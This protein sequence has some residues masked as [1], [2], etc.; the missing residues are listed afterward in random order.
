MIS[1]YLPIA[2]LVLLG[3]GIAMGTIGL[4]GD[5]DDVWR[6][7]LFLTVT[8]MPL[9]VIRAVREAQRVTADQLA[10]ADQAGY[11]RALDHVARGLLDQYT[12]PPTPGTRVPA[13]EQ[14]T[15]V[16]IP[17]RPTVYTRQERKAL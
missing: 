14:A 6:C 16:V 3:A 8:A 15:G 13:A 7:G 9:L 2:P 10:Q 11:R 1:R 12:A 4:L 17:L 5:N